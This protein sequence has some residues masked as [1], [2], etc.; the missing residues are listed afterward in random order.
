MLRRF[1]LTEL[2]DKSSTD[3]AQVPKVGA[4]VDLYRQ[5]ATMTTGGAIAG[6][7][8]LEVNVQSVGALVVGDTVIAGVSGPTLSVVTINAS[9]SPLKV[10]LHNALGSSVTV[11]VGDRLIPTTARPAVYADPFGTTLLGS[12][13]STDASGRVGGYVNATPFDYTVSP[14]AVAIVAVTAWTF[15][16]SSASTSWAHPAAGPGSIVLVGI[17]WQET[18]A[19]E[20]L[21]SVTYGGVA[22]TRLGATNMVDL[23]YLL[24]PP[25]GPQT[26]LATWSG[27]SA[28]GVVA[29]A[30]TLVGIDS[31][32]PLGTLY[33]AQGTS[34]SPSVAVSGTHVNGLLLSVVAVNAVASLT[35]LTTSQNLL[36]SD[37]AGTS[38]ATTRT[39]GGGST[40]PG[41]G[42]TVSM[43]W[44]LGASKPWGILAVE[45]LPAPARLIIDAEGTSFGHS[46]YGINAA[47]YP[48]LKAAVDA[49]P[50]G[51]GTVF[52][53]AGA[54]ILDASDLPIVL[55]RAIQII[56]EGVFTTSVYVNSVAG[57]ENLNLFE[58][59]NSFCSIENM[60]LY[61]H[62][63]PET[64]GTGVGV[65]IGDPDGATIVVVT[66][67]NL[68][69]YRF[70]SYGVQVVG[71]SEQFY[72]GLDESIFEA[73][74]V[75]GSQSH[76]QFGL[77][78]GTTTTRLVNCRA[79]DGV[80]GGPTSPT[81]VLCYEIINCA[82]IT[83]DTCEGSPPSGTHA[84]HIKQTTDVGNDQDGGANITI[85]NCDFERP[86]RNSVAYLRAE[87]VAG[88]ILEGNLFYDS[89]TD[90]I[91]L[92]QCYAPLVQGN[93]F[94]AIDNWCI[95]LDDCR[96]AVLIAN[97][98]EATAAA[99]GA[100]SVP[101]YTDGG[102][103]TGTSVFA[104]GI[105]KPPGYPTASLPAYDAQ[106]VPNGA[107]CFNTTTG[108]LL[109]MSGGGWVVVGTQT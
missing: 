78:R 49:V 5:G 87:L 91:V 12:T 76:A 73:V 81:G 27:A 86:E 66:L 35:T 71:A 80:P 9:V 55:D 77:G 105:V 107:L 74:T 22:M 61:G 40:A 23:F 96:N 51:G 109:V 72:G 50:P 25:A 106:R 75:A 85:R 62:Q 68:Q 36:W 103:S 20:T 93:V 64:T 28:K 60:T 44:T 32:S 90:G 65:K 41:T 84:V 79:Y 19:S 42:G 45:A 67:R 31:N 24:N 11:K 54:Y 17:S 33:S 8:D 99:G 47:D 58:I 104:G 39:Q 69:I 59:E 48:T 83:L 101:N 15:E 89:S 26:V 98:Y 70:A 52:V 34:T 10:K 21:D 4:Q 7:A 18:T 13:L 16:G 92:A 82:N 88:L 29:G 108:K 57:N 53:P 100:R 97:S 63:D 46:P 3:R 102:T 14:S 95:Y 38:G 30:V 2:R 1:D 43:A 94:C 56:G 37:K 6:G